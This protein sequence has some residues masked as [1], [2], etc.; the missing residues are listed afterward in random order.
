MKFFDLS[1]VDSGQLAGRLGYKKAF[2]AGKDLRIVE[3]LEENGERKG[4]VR[5]ADHEVVVKMLRQGWVVGLLPVNCSV[6]RQTL[7]EMRDHEKAL[8]V[9]LS[10]VTC[11][12]SSQQALNMARVLVR[13]ALRAGVAISIVSMAR[14][15]ECLLSSAQAI[16][17]AGFLGMDPRRAREAL[18]TLGGLV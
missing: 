18:G 17:V 15:R 1:Y 16:E 9:P 10:E 13:N 5:S 14:D 12:E 7:E 6:S 11:A 3:K 8:F 2:V 4:I